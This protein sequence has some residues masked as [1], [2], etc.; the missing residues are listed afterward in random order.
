MTPNPT[1][2][3][4]ATGKRRRKPK[5]KRGLALLIFALI[6]LPVIRLL[7]P[8]QPQAQSAETSKAM[9]AQAANAPAPAPL[10]IGQ[11]VVVVTMANWVSCK[12]FDDTK[13]LRE[14]IRSHDM[15]AV[16]RFIGIK[17]PAGECRYLPKGTVATVEDSNWYGY[18]CI[19]P[20]GDIDC[21]W[22][23]RPMLEDAATAAAEDKKWA[24]LNTK[25]SERFDRDQKS[26]AA[27]EQSAFRI[28]DAQEMPITGPWPWQGV[29]D[30][31]KD[32][33]EFEDCLIQA[34]WR[35]VH[36]FN[37]VDVALTHI[38]N[39]WAIGRPRAN[40]RLAIVNPWHVPI[41]RQPAVQP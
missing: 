26:Y 3:D 14:L 9:A 18:Y 41:S 29:S 39:C 31:C 5:T 21:L 19:R 20:E 40:C 33:T 8:A 1:W 17:E 2:H 10:S 30:D 32:E 38:R 25:L 13:R 34:K 27:L 23:D 24:A 36:R 4:N 35:F 11:R 22:A 15:A 16:S 12:S 37:R 6:A 28:F 7:M